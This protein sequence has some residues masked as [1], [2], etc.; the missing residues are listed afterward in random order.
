MILL[1]AML[2]SARG[3]E[4]AGMRSSELQARLRQFGAPESEIKGC[5]HKRDLV[6]LHDRYQRAHSTRGTPP[7]VEEQSLSSCRR[8]LMTSQVSLV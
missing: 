1:A 5:I 7:T 8:C 2:L 4:M 6:A 3:E